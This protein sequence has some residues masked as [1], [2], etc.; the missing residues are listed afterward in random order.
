MDTK[1]RI[2]FD[3]E[4][5]QLAL[6][7]FEEHEKNCK[8]ANKNGQFFNCRVVSSPRVEDFIRISNNYPH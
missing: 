6:K 7:E 5:Y 4:A 8:E 2:F 1:P 3:T